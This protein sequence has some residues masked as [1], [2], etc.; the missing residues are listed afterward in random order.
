MDGPALI[1]GSRA[2]ADSKTGNGVLKYR[3]DIDGL[4]A[5]AVGGVVLFHAFPTLLTGGF[6]GVDVF[7]VLSGYLITAII[8][9]DAEAGTFSIAGFYERRFRRILPALLAMVVVTSLAAVAILPPSELGNYGKSLAGVGLF[10]S[11]I[12]FWNDSGYFDTASANKP[13]LHTWSLAVEEQFYIVWPIVAALLVRMGRRRLLAGFVWA[14]VG[15][16]LLAAI[17]AVRYAPSQAFYLLPYRAWELGMGALLAT[18]AVPSLRTR[19]MR[20]ATAWAGLALIVVPM[21]V[22]T[23]A[24][25]FP[26]LAALPPCLGALLILHAGQGVETQ[27]GRMLSWRP[28]LFVGLV[29]YSFYL[30]HWPLLVLPRIALNRPL[31]PVEAVLA[32]AVALG[33]AALSLRHVER[34][35]RG[36]GTIALSRRKVLSASVAGCAALTLAGAGLFATRGLQAFAA[37]DVIAAERAVDS[38]NPLRKACHNDEGTDVLGPVDRCTGGAPRPDGGYQVLLWGDS[39]ADHLAAGFDRLGREQGFAFRQAS[40]SGCEALAIFDTD[41]RRQACAEYH[42]KALAE[43]AGQPDLRAI[44]ISSR[45]SRSLPGRAAI[46]KSEPASIQQTHALLTRLVRRIRTEV[47]PRPAIILIGSTPEFDFWPATC[48]ARAAKSGLGRAQ[49]TR[50]VAADREWGPK[51]DR[52]LSGIA[53][54]TAILPRRS[55]CAGDLCRTVAGDTIL[56]RDDDHLTNEGAWFVARQAAAAIASARPISGPPA[57]R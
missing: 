28:M 34:P 33:L 14:T 18:G 39:H 21:L 43:A 47:G 55:Y 13:L 35:F 16:S 25:P 45:W 8:R 19:G 40:V 41:D 42:R 30:W 46:L 4:R 3:T 38:I 15:L 22:Y 52:V 1:T 57:T 6:I 29:S 17:A 49:C 9:S 7:F 11:N 36:R 50:A 23:E 56:Y 51:A 5:V 48:L 31:T 26:G 27:A 20:E 12:V 44:V 2:A 32:V 53:G 10:A 24:T 54:V 37:P